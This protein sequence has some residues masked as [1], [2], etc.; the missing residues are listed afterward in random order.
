MWPM[1]KKPVTPPH[2]SDPP[3]KDPANADGAPP[4]AQTPDVAQL[5]ADA[6]KPVTDKLGTLDQIN[7]RLQTVE[8]RVTPKPRATEGDQPKLTSFM[9]DEDTAFAQRVSPLLQRQLEL[10]ARMVFDQVRR[11]YEQ[12]G[13]SELFSTYQEEINKTLEGS[14][15]AQPDGQGGMK[16]LRGDPQY[17]RNV[18]DMVL[19]RAAR[20][21]GIKFD[22]AKKQFFLETAGGAEGGGSRQPDTDGMTDKQR[23][24]FTRMGVPLDKAKETMG[25]LE[26]V[27]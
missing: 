18:V 25:K 17:I 8:E 21:G 1:D 10:E 27:K 3:T 14:P 26:F 24:I 11:E 7:T 13:F 23:Q 12:S 16:A 2:P 19:G 5:I 20:K 22:G 9:E 6:L 4:P 15:L